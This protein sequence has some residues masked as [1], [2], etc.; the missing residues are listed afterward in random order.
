MLAGKVYAYDDAECIDCHGRKDGKSR[1]TMDLAVFKASAH[2][3]QAECGDCHSQ[4]V[5]EG[6]MHTPGSG[7][8]DCGQCHDTV[9]AHGAKGPARARPD[10]AACHSRHG[11][12]T[13]SDPASTV[14]P[15]KRSV[16]CGGCHQAQT[17]RPDYLSFLPAAQIRSHPKENFGKRYSRGNCIGCHQGQAVHGQNTIIDETD[18]CRRCHMDAEGNSALMGVIHARADLAMQPGIFAAGVIYQLILLALLATG[19]AFTVTRISRR[20][21]SQGEQTCGYRI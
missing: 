7:A 9:N 5:D 20:L 21:R 6:H 16:T 19:G 18:Q 10:C 8:V 12:L 11:I 13:A 3:G 2:N 14:H 15:A 1:L 4:V 17:G